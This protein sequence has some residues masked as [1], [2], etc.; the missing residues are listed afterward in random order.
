MLVSTKLNAVTVYACERLNLV[1][2]LHKL[3]LDTLCSLPIL[4]TRGVRFSS[5][6]LSLMLL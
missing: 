1:M 3:E 4:V 6:D 5:Q 2:I